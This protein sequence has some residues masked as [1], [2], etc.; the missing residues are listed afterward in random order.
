[1]LIQINKI[2]K[3]NLFS[4]SQIDEQGITR[5]SLCVAFKT[6]E[7]D[8]VDVGQIWR[9]EGK[10]EIK[11]F[12]V[13]GYNVKEEQFDAETA[14]FIKPNTALLETW[15][16]KNVEGVG[17]VKAR[18]LARMSELESIIEAGDP[19]NLLRLPEVSREQLL[20][21]FPR[22]VYAEAIKWLSSRKLPVKLA[23]S[24]SSVWREKTIELLEDNPFRLMQFNVSFKQ[25]CK[26]AEEFGY[27]VNHPK[28][29]AAL[30]VNI[31]EE[32]ITQTSSTFIPK[33]TFENRCIKRRIDY[34][35]ALKFAAQQELVC[36]LK[37]VDGYQLEG[38]YLLE[39]MTGHKLREAFF[40]KD[41][42]LS[43]LAS[44]EKA[45]S[46]KEIAHHLHQFEE[47]L[48]YSLTEEQRSAV[49]QACKWKV[50]SLSGGAGTGKTT[51]LNAVLSVLEA[52]SL[53]T[54]IYQVALSGR[55]SQRMSEATGRPASTIAKF[56]I[57]MKNIA[58]DKRPDHAI[59]VIDEA[60]MVD[61]FSMHN[62]LQYLPFA[63]RFIFV[64]DVDQLPPV[65][66]GLIFHSM[67]KSDFP[68][69]TLTAVKRQ[70]EQSG[71]HKFATAVRNENED[72][73]L[74]KFSDESDCILFGSI[75]PEQ[76]QNL[77]DGLNSK[78][79]N[80]ILTATQNGAAGVKNLNAVMQKAKGLDRQ[81]VFIDQGDGVYDYVSAS[82]TKFYLN[83]PVLITKNDYNIGIRNGDLGVIETIFEEQD[84]EA[85]NQVF[86]VL[87][88]D[89]RKI[90]LTF[91][92][93]DRMELGYAITIHKSQGSQ[94]RNVILVLDAQAHRMLDKTL[95][96]TGA[97]RAEKN[98][99]ICCENKDLIEN[100]VAKGSIALRRNTNLSEH[101]KRDI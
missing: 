79:S 24:I 18:K 75:E 19:K 80:I 100:A 39:A 51:V 58:D 59:V 11:R 82:G 83:D 52:V 48:A 90:D 38:Q 21:K 50:I 101:L 86:G 89:G 37:D 61:L 92:V 57:D 95:L 65:G 23:N 53:D 60:S 71:I 93:L 35:E 6:R 91:N 15:L 66:G 85:D 36:Y 3:N 97:T 69:V 94:W 13:N 17:T 72:I 34:R 99:I 9:V 68:S 55:A 27:D 62:L 70:G 7:S 40:R 84:L 54:P 2:R 14:E 26:V 32:Y 77:F 87:D 74:D 29:K 5:K 88:I 76:I 25:C 49:A 33:R 44:W 42:D 12:V 67:M 47:T 45:V 41:G 20:R 22:G 64:G 31:I 56:C 16:R 4:A 81:A 28:Y 1:M 63:T 43:E 46:D 73:K 96:Y 8:A 10:S 98:L 30:V 78:Q